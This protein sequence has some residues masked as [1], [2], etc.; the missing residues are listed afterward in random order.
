MKLHFHSSRDDHNH[1]C[2]N[3]CRLNVHAFGFTSFHFVIFGSSFSFISNRKFIS[4]AQMETCNRKK[5][6]KEVNDK[7][8]NSIVFSNLPVLVSLSFPVLV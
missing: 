3:L 5:K 2:D 6:K 1:S 4:H 7:Q 8:I